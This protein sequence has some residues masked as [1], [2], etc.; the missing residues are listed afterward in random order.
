MISSR[1]D[2]PRREMIMSLLRRFLTAGGGMLAW[3]PSSSHSSAPSIMNSSSRTAA[4]CCRNTRHTPAHKRFHLERILRVFLA[5]SCFWSSEPWTDSFQFCTHVAKALPTAPLVQRE[6]ALRS[7]RASTLPCTNVS[8]AAASRDP[9]RMA[10]VRADAAA[11]TRFLYMCRRQALQ[12]RSELVLLRCQLSTTARMALIFCFVLPSAVMASIQAFKERESVACVHLAKIL[13]RSKRIRRCSAALS[14]HCVMA[15]V[16]AP[17]RHLNSTFCSRARCV[18]AS[19]TNSRHLFSAM[20]SDPFRQRFKI[21][22]T[23]ARRTRCSRM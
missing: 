10:A 18:L 23:L 13:A 5:A 14:C 15:F 4:S 12:A 11:R 19:L 2:V 22:A 7:L 6:R 17:L 9:A 20:T 8:K 3:I 16:S 1:E 21:P